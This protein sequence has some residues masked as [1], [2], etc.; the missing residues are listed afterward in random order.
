MYHLIRHF[1][2]LV[3]RANVRIY[4][5]DDCNGS[6]S[7]KSFL[8]FDDTCHQRQDIGWGSFQISQVDKHQLQVISVRPSQ[9]WVLAKDVLPS[10]T[11]AKLIK[12]N[13]AL[14]KELDDLKKELDQCKKENTDL[15][16]SPFPGPEYVAAKDHCEEVYQKIKETKDKEARDKETSRKRKVPKSDLIS[17]SNAHKKL[18]A[19]ETPPPTTLSPI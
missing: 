16:L 4:N 1:S 2:T 12:E 5:W 7:Y 19:A 3:P 9:F 10:D 18:K 8:I 14:K 6:C 17:D 13:D 11:V 15:R